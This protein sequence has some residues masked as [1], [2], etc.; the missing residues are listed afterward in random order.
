MICIFHNPKNIAQA[1]I[2]C[3]VFFTR[4]QKKLHQ[5]AK[6]KGKT[7]IPVIDISAILHYNRFI[8][9]GVGPI[10]LRLS[11]TALSPVNLIRIMPS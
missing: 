10:R 7:A 11:E 4:R 1:G 6:E 8:L 9:R 2:N 3:K 5:A